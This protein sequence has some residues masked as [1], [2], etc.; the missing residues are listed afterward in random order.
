MSWVEGHP[1]GNGFPEMRKCLA[2]T[3]APADREAVRQ[4]H[5]I[6]RARARTTDSL[7]FQTLI[8]QKAIQHAPGKDAMCTAALQAQANELFRL[9]VNS[10]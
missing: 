9:R 3:F 1:I 10:F 4:H 6:H 7:D 5:G 8:L 2:R